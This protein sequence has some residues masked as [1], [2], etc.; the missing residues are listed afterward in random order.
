VTDCV[1]K[2]RYLVDTG[3]ELCVFPRKLLP[4]RRA[5]IDYSLY[6]DNGT[7]IPIY[8]WTS[9]SL[10]LGLRHDFTW[11]FI[12]AEVEL[13]IIGVDFLAHFNLLV[14]C[15]NN[16]LLDGITSLFTQDNS[17]TPVVLSIQA[18]ASDATPD[19]LPAKFP[20]LTRPTGFNREVHHN[21]TRHIRTTPGPPVV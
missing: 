16:G 12:V 8:G 6:A 19:S 10:N 7:T 18:I 1:T 9:R 15:R 2:T 11:R 20:S 3:S 17:A 5:R 13:P 14:D 4:E 21:T